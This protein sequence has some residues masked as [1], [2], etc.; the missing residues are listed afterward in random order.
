MRERNAFA[1]ASFCNKLWNRWATDY[2]VE[3]VAQAKAIETEWG[4]GDSEVSGDV[5]VVLDLLI[6]SR[7]VVVAFVPNKPVEAVFI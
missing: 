3:A 5:V 6:L 4:G 7:R 1:K 2:R